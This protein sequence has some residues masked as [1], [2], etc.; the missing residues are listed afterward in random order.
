MVHAEGP[1]T[2]GGEAVGES[3]EA[4]VGWIRRFIR[5]HGLRH[6]AELGEPDIERF[7]SDL[8]ELSRVSASTQTQALSALLFLYRDV[9]HRPPSQLQGL[10]RARR[11]ER[12]PVVLGREEVRLILRTLE[13]TPR[14]A[15]M[16]LYGAG[17]RLLECLELRIKDLDFSRGQIL[18]RRGK[19]AK[20]RITM[21]PDG[22]REPLRVHLSDLRRRYQRDLAKG[23]AR[24]PLPAALDRKLRGATAE[25]AW[26][27]VFPA[28]RPWREPRTGLLVRHHLH[29]SVVQRAVRDA[30][31]TAA[32]PKRATSHTFR[33]SFATHLLEDG[34]DI[35]T[36]QEL[37]GHRD[38]AT[39]MIYTHVLDRGAFGV[40]SP[41]DRL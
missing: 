41:M 31:R 33:H 12:V 34:Y 5:Y 8:A 38:V 22:A 29:E 40:R 3:E 9:L 21:L 15:A 18:V 25:W 27:W 14:L 17:L 20:D 23:G 26:Q 39:T 2:E 28:V 16:L 11:P 35:R 36:V 10:V 30:V 6:P 24:V 13:G 19:G 7:L 1:D 37:L 4:Y 32:L